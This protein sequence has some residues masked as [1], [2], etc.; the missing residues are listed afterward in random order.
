MAKPEISSKDIFVIHAKNNRIK[1]LLKYK[2]EYYILKTGEKLAVKPDLPE[3]TNKAITAITQDGEEIIA[4]RLNECGY[5]IKNS[6]CPRNIRKPININ[7]INKKAAIY[8]YS[9]LFLSKDKLIKI[10]NSYNRVIDKIN[11]R[12]ELSRVEENAK[13]EEQARI[14]KY[15]KNLIR[16]K[17]KDA[18]E[19][20]PN[21]LN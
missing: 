9:S 4:L 18:R 8:L 6:N 21:L 2:Q 16:Q 12:C 1:F 15:K 14:K 7:L 5:P 17:I 10:E 13:K 3:L 19:N 20:Y 11:F